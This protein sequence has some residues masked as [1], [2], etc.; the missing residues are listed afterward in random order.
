[1]D[2]TNPVGEVP[3]NVPMA[4]K[5]KM[6]SQVPLLMLILCVSAGALYGMRRYGM[7]EGYTFN[8]VK[9]DFKSDE[10]VK[11]RTYERIMADLNRIQKPLDVT[12][13]E[14]GKSPF[15]RERQQA[16][17]TPDTGPIQP[18]MSDADRHRAEAVDALKRMRLRGIIGNVARI[19]DLTVKAGDVIDIFTVK[20]VSGRTVT[21]EAYGEPFSLT[22]EEPK[23]GGPKKSPTRMGNAPGN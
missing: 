19:D 23:A 8:E 16:S 3:L 17:V 11:A 21:F 20:S 7:Q 1:M 5:P 6:P 22:L 13:T 10:S 15:M 2:T 4:R 12:L 18:G 9:V 14:F